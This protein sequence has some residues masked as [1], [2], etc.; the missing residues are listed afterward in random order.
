LALEED[1]YEPSFLDKIRSGAESFT[2]FTGSL[3]SSIP[4]IGPGL[5]Y[6]E[7]AAASISPFGEDRTLEEARAEG[8]LRRSEEIERSPIAS[9]VGGLA[10]SVIAPGGPMLKAA[11]GAGRLARAGTLGA[12]VLGQAGSQVGISAADQLARSGE[13]DTEM[14]EDEAMLAGGITA[15]GGVLGA[16]GKTAK[17]IQDYLT[18]SSYSQAEKAVGLESSKKIRQTMSE[19]I[20]KGKIEEYEIGKQ[21]MDSGAIKAGRSNKD[22]A[23]FATRQKEMI[24]EKIGEQIAEANPIPTG[25][26]RNQLEGVAKEMAQLSTEGTTKKRLEKTI[27]EIKALEG[28]DPTARQLKALIN[29][30][31]Q[32]LADLE[33]LNRRMGLPPDVRKEY[34]GIKLAHDAAT[35]TLESLETFISPQKVQSLKSSVGASIKD[36]SNVTSAEKKALLEEYKAFSAGLADAVPNK[37]AYQK[38]N[39]KYEIAKFLEAASENK[40]TKGE[41]I[42]ELMTSTGLAS[43]TPEVALA[44]VTRGMWN[45]YGNSLAAAGFKKMSSMAGIP[46]HSLNALSAAAERGGP[47]AVRAAH[48]LMMQNDEKYRKAVSKNNEKE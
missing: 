8:E 3:Q 1:A 29:K 48:F 12:N 26:L 6:L 47:S 4:I 38:L 33:D 22:M 40:L 32:R 16:G 9:T 46:K 44:G 18:R 23:D 35:E 11:Q 20:D 27:R 5:D 17:A 28:K 39:K 42:G 36:F 13:L 24:G 14:L 41:G 34:E 31:G 21:L 25:Q 43:G 30:T 37:D 19:F 15:A 45:K 10:G 2:D 7:D